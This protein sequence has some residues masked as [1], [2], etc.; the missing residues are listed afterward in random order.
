MLETDITKS[1]LRKALRK[2]RREHVAA[3]PDMVRGLLFNMPPRPLL[4]KID[5]GAVI[6]LYHATKFEA[7]TNAYARFFHEAGHRVALPYFA[8]ESAQ[9]EFREH[10]DPFGE[11]DLEPGAFGLVQPASEAQVIS[12][13]IV[14]VPLIGFTERLERLGQGG[15]H[16]DRWLAAHPDTKAIGLAWDVQLCEELP[17]EP[18]D[19]KLG[20]VITPTRM[21]G[22]D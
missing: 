15:G 5:G 6:G 3:Q 12:P 17:L 2:A 13:D 7:P 22:L 18:H 4:P 14:F 11:T 19:M 10:T 1:D 21:Y 20:G 16:Y 8:D 9:M